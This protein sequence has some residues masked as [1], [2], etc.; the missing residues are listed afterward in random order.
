MS[1]EQNPNALKLLISPLLF[2]QYLSFLTKIKI[3]FDQKSSRLI[4]TQLNN[5]ELKQRIKLISSFL[6]KELNTEKNIIAYLDTIFKS[7]HK[8]IN[9][10]GLQWWP[11]SDIIEEMSRT[12]ENMALKYMDKLTQVFTSE[13]AVRDLYN[14]RPKLVLDYL[15]KNSKHHNL[16]LRRWASEGSRPFLPWG[17]KADIFKTNPKA[18]LKI[19]EQLKYDE[20]LYV[21]KSV[22]NHL[23]DLSKINADLVLNVLK[24]WKKNCKDQEVKKIDWIINHSLRTLIKKGNKAALALTQ[25]NLSDHVKI[26]SC[27]INK[28]K[29]LVSDRII[30]SIELL[31][32]NKNDS[33]FNLD[34]AIIYQAKSGKPSRKVY[35]GKKGTLSAQKSLEFNLNHHLKKISTRQFYS[36]EHRLEL[37][38]NGEIT[39]IFIFQLSV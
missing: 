25:K 28:K 18:T 8:E 4:S 29:F 11:L 38:L 35:R 31:N 32:E 30:I 6:L 26:S 17:K 22:A 10:Q 23:N 13:F 15:F 3:Q 12:N 37:I 39:K 33:S 19:L 7:D 21:R 27:Q 9:I 16:H 20:E 24:D 36:G 5:L 34:Y 2:K 14:N 1:K